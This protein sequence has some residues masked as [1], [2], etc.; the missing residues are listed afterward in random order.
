[1]SKHKST[2]R[3]DSGSKK[4]RKTITPG[5]TL[6]T[7][8]KYKHNE[9]TGD[10]DNTIG[11]PNLTLRTIRKQADK[12]KNSRKIAMRMMASVM[13]QTSL[14]IMTKLETC[15]LNGLSINTNVPLLYPP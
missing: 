2:D 11:I 4:Q 5:D 1:M 14:P 6:D 7:I 15:W 13:T 12:I 3:S 10:I 8:W 9:I